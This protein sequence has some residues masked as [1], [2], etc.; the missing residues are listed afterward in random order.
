ML[1]LVA[2]S[3]CRSLHIVRT[4]V[5][6][7]EACSTVIVHLTLFDVVI[8]HYVQAGFTCAEALVTGTC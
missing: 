7:L 4:A 5:H 8:L 6:R 1:Y 3:A 2:V